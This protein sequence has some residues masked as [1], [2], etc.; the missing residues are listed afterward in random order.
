MRKNIETAT[1]FANKIKNVKGILQIILFG[2]VATNQDKESSD[3]D[4][5]IVYSNRD[6]FSLIKEVNLKKPEKVQ[7]TFLELKQLSK[8]TELVGAVSGEGL[9]LYGR[10]IIIQSNK[11]N[12]MPKIIISYNLSKLKQTE[13]V[14]LNRALYGS[15]SK[16]KLKNKQYITYTHGLIKEAGI[17]KINNSVLMVDRTKSKKIMNLLKR[18]NADF[19]EI[20]IWTY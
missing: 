10:P 15:V 12:L 5:A 9:L 18:F 13:K 14:K 16:S 6:K 11:L 3:I 17:E 20:P 19:R 7:T 1:K 2:S 4:I 8:E